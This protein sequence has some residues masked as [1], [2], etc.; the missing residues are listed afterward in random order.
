MVSLNHLSKFHL[1]ILQI[2]STARAVHGEALL[3]G[4]PA[5]AGDIYI[6]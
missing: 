5:E 6:G 3:K 2:E 1:P 4:V